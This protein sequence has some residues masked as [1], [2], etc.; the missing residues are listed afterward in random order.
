MMSYA[1]SLIGVIV[2]I[3]A[4]VCNVGKFPIPLNLKHKPPVAAGVPFFAAQ[5]REVQ[6]FA[7]QKS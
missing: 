5:K 1:F 6:S 2:Y 7:T 3:S 4:Q